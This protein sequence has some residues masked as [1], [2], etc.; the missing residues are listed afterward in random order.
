VTETVRRSVSYVITSLDYGGAERQLVALAR[1]FRSRGWDVSVTTLI[2]PRAFQ[3]LLHDDGIRLRSL[4]MRRGIPD[5]GAL[6][7]L[8]G[9]FHQ[10]RPTV[11]HSHMVHANLLAR[12]AR[13][14]APVPYLVSTAHSVTE[15]ARWREL[16][17]RWT[18]P[19]CDL[20]TNVS[21]A[22]VDRY[23]QCGAAPSAKIR[24][25]PN[26]VDLESFERRDAAASAVRSALGIEQAFVWLA[27][28]RFD[29]VKDYAAMLRAFAA[30]QGDAVL[31][32]AGEGEQRG[33]MEVLAER[34]GVA[35]RVRFLGVRDDVADLLSA[36]DGFVLSS[37]WEGLP[38]VLLEAAAA[39]LPIVATDVGGVGEV[40][41]D[42][43]TGYL[44]A[45]GDVEALSA[46]MRRLTAVPTEVRR[47][48]GDAGR[49]HAVANFDIERVVDGW[50]EIY[51]AGVEMAGGRSRRLA[52]R[53]SR[54]ERR[55]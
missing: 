28:G 9:S 43:T 47:K 53:P 36:A 33:E 23:V 40:V 50:E 22:G 55:A 39:S 31:V 6:M 45:P 30:A 14:L 2:A 13:L 52:R 3:P 16:A 34:L 27:V 54:T 5:P 32:I 51:L 26:G 8:A 35:E 38:M 12:S 18:D 17:Y 21:A 37:L 10:H 44:A 1:R 49:R 46:A 19:M 48:M 42:A 7:R 4:Q 25:V 41:R 20:T 29:P 15:G 24:Y 11:V